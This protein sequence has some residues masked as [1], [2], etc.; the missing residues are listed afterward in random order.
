MREPL[1]EAELRCALVG[2]LHEDAAAGRLS[3]KR[4]LIPFLAGGEIFHDAAAPFRGRIATP[5][6]TLD[7]VPV[8]SCL[9]Y[10]TMLWQR[11]E[12]GEP[13]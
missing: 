10:A 3:A 7:K 12:R 5:G 8:F 2:E 13:T 4:N 11:R 1:L 6:R 9:E